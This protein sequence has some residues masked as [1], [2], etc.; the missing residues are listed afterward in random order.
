MLR[1]III[2]AALAAATAFTGAAPAGAQ[3][4]P[5]NFSL[6]TDKKAMRVEDVITVLILEDAKAGSDAKTSTNKAQD[7]SVDIKPLSVEWSG[8]PTEYTPTVGFGGGVKH[9]YDGSGRTSRNGEVKAT[10]SARIIAV[11]DN[12]NLLIEGNKEV[13]INGEKEILRVSG[14]VRP[15]DIS[16]DNTILS[17]KIADS[18]IQYTG[19]GDSHQASRPGWLAR[20]INWVF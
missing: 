5:K 16:P 9:K 1:N 6:Y 15:E 13:E 17:E 18:R 2:V 8:V 20:F 7:A 4:L 14:I 10:V 12:G 3:A 19:Q 11:Y